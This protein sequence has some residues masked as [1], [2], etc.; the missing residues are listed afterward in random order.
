MFEK[1]VTWIFVQLYHVTKF[2]RCSDKIQFKDVGLNVQLKGKVFQYFVGARDATS[3]KTRCRKLG[4]IK[5][6]NY[7]N[8]VNIWFQGTCL[9]N[10]LCCRT[11]EDYTQ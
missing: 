6:V 9:L 7:A 5:F 4:R 11:I 2:F 3:A 10:W 1:P 8:G